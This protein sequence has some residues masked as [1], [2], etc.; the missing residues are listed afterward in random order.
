MLSISEGITLSEVVSIF[1]LN[2]IVD[3]LLQSEHFLNVK[4]CVSLVNKIITD[5]FLAALVYSN[6]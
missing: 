3:F 2:V 1:F 4:C 5:S 6:I